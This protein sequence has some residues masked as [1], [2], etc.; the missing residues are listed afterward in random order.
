MKKTLLIFALVAMSFHTYA[1]VGI[2]TETPQAALDIVSTNS[3]IMLP[4][5][6]NT[7]AVSTAVNGMIVYDLSLNCFNFYENGAWSGCKTGSSNVADVVESVNA[8]NNVDG[9]MTIAEL[10]AILPSINNV[11][12]GY[13]SEYQTYITNNP[14]S[15]SSP[16][17]QT[18][19]Q[20]MVTATNAATTIS[21]S[22][23][24][25]AGNT[26]SL[27]ELTAAGITGATGSQ[28]DYELAI[29]TASTTPTNLADL[30]GI[31]NTVNIV[32]ASNS[33]AAGGMPS[34]ADLTNAGVTGATGSQTAYEVAIEASSPAPTTVADLQVIINE[35]NT[36]NSIVSTSN[37]PAADC[38]PSLA[39]L[40][41]AGVSGAT[42]NQAAYELAINAASP[43]PITL[44]QLQVIIDATNTET[45]TV[46]G[47]VSASNSPAA[48]GTP[49]LAELST[50]GITGA[51][52]SQAAYELAI[53]AASPAPITLAQLQVIIGDANTEMNTVATI[54]S[55]SGATANG[56]S[57]IADLTA[58][59]VTGTVLA[60]EASYETVLNAAGTA[61]VT[62]A[63]L[64]ALVTEVN[65]VTSIVSASDTP[66]A[67]GTPSLS[68]LSTAGVT[69][70]TGSQA[71]Y[72]LAINAASPAPKTLAA[73]QALI[74]AANAEMS[75]VATIVS[76][77]GTSADGTPSIADLTAAGVT[78]TVPANEAAYEVAINAAS[79]APVTLANLQ[80]LINTENEK[81]AVAAIVAASDS[82]ADGTP[83]IA[84]LQAVGV[85]NIAAGVQATLEEG[86]ADA[87]P[88]PTTLAGLQ[89]VIDLVN[90]LPLPG[91]I[92][93]TAGQNAFIASIY[94]TNYLPYT[95]PGAGVTATTAVSNA[96]GT[97]DPTIDVQGTLTAATGITV[98]I[99]YTVLNATVT[100]PAYTVTRTVASSLVV[101]G[102]AH[103]VIFSYDG[104]SLNVGSGTFSATIKAVSTDLD[105]IKLDINAG[106]GANVLGILMASFPVALDNAGTLGTVSLRVV[107]GILDRAFGDGDHDFIYLP[108]LGE[109]GNTWLNNNL[110]AH[111]SN[112]GH[113]NFNPASQATAYNDHLAY[114]S[115]YQWGRLSDG[116]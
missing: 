101:G 27:A 114:G 70:A 109:D 48:G 15:F 33:P 21:A 104:Q 59:G 106:I 86:I 8:L 110:G 78:G 36:V 1:Q 55:N 103:D 111:Y 26:P 18:E 29:A 76:N 28:A 16:A 4:R 96:D 79:P 83:S 47:I 31:I 34:L 44:A 40:T 74:N 112:V 93:L 115:L 95:A 105:A 64:Q 63:Q 89:A 7:D 19:V 13:E 65:T 108:V 75:T 67:G 6:A 66:A 80:D 94:D 45:T 42:V 87:S 23:N 107:A 73:L 32:V 57:S 38:T 35:A 39:E 2:G 82:P 22:N 71:A 9:T 52:G 54:V 17:T 68:D 99:P 58:A 88:A 20:N 49:S 10:N 90:A 50:A 46:A 11:V 98:Q 43:A 37:S 56:T 41:A 60:N 24:P 85:L 14:G 72:E 77:S 69:G 51:T 53:N 113:A 81:I 62:L 84:E 97:A 61:T 92:T 25:A 102:A 91:D 5:V 12:A 3:G 100:L 116:H 30:Q